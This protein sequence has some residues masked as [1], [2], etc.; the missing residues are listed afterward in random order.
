MY[1]AQSLVISSRLAKFWNSGKEKYSLFSGSYRSHLTLFKKKFVRQI[2]TI[3]YRVDPYFYQKCFLLKGCTGTKQVPTAARDA[4]LNKCIPSTSCLRKSNIKSRLNWSVWFCTNC[5]CFFKHMGFLGGA[6]GKEP[7]CQFERLG[8][9][10]WVGKISWRRASQ[11]T[12][13]FL[14]GKS[15]G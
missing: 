11:P 1:V 6:S 4:V 8:L 14:P 12:P 3:K 10:P 7:T 13:V 5:I 2:L 9:S 15:H